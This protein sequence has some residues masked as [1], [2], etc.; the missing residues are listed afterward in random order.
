MTRVRRKPARVSPREQALDQDYALA[1]AIYEVGCYTA[2]QRWVEHR[3]PDSPNAKDLFRLMDCLHD[4]K[5]EALEICD[6][7]ATQTLEEVES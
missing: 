1:K 6:R 4:I 3:H 2:C 5:K 7:V